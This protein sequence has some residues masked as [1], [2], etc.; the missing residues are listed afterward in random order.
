MDHMGYPEFLVGDSE[1]KLEKAIEDRWNPVMIKNLA[2][3][4][5]FS[6]N[7]NVLNTGTII[8]AMKFDKGVLTASDGRVSG[9]HYVYHDAFEKILELDN[10]S[11]ILISGVAGLCKD[12]VLTIRVITENFRKVRGRELTTKGKVKQIAHFVKQFL[13]AAIQMQ[14]MIIPVFASY[15]PGEGGRIYCFGPDG[16]YIEK[17]YHADGS[18]SMIATPLLEELYR[19]GMA[20]EKTLKLAVK[21]LKKAVGKDGAC[22]GKFFIKII[23]EN[24]IRPIS[25]EQILRAGG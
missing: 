7:T 8:L 1:K 15:K 9:G 20:E 12:L 5:S 17:E 11:V 21:L 4:L 2:D 22:G 18:G 3:V 25:D 14:L 19:V 24:G 23:D 6:G 13:M 10:R 16:T